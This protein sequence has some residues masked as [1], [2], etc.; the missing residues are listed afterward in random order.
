MLNFKIDPSH[1]TLDK[2]S[3]RDAQNQAQRASSDNMRLQEQVGKLTFIVE[4][5]W[6]ILKGKHNLDDEVLKK[7]VVETQA[8]KKATLEEPVNC[9]KCSRLVSPKSKMCVFCGEKVEQ[10]EIFPY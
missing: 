2:E 7:M 8:R 6:N 3:L 9:K 5:L 10:S 1:K 4:S